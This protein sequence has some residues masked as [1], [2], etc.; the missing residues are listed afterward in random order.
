VSEHERPSSQLARVFVF[1]LVVLLGGI[2]CLFVKYGPSIWGMLGGVALVAIAGWLL[3][4][5]QNDG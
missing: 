3:R 2:G 4:A 5:A 1:L